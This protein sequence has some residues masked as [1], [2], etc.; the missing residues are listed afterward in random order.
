[1]FDYQT[2]TLNYKIE[3]TK[4]EEKFEILML[5]NRPKTSYDT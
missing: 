1:M 3:W 5:S 4:I 2:K